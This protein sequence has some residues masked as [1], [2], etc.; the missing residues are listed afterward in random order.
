MGQCGCDNLEKLWLFSRSLTVDMGLVGIGHWKGSRVGVSILIPKP[1]LLK[2]PFAWKHHW[3][4]NLLPTAYWMQLSNHGCHLLMFPS[5]NGFISFTIFK[6]K[7]INQLFVYYF[8]QRQN[9]LIE[10]KRLA[11][12]IFTVIKEITY[13]P[14]YLYNYLKDLSV[15]WVLLNLLN[16]C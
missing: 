7:P 5:L 13:L 14:I 8:L 10:S 1:I 11:R 9:S 4:I 16:S 15:I 6:Q 2:I 12:K 3:L